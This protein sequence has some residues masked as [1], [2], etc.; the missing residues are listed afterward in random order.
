MQ[1]P[2]DAPEIRNAKKRCNR[3]R[4]KQR[5]WHPVGVRSGQEARKSIKKKKK[6][7]RQKGEKELQQNEASTGPSGGECE[8]PRG[9]GPKIVPDK[10]GEKRTSFGPAEGV[11]RVRGRVWAGGGSGPDRRWVTCSRH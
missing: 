1:A 3:S 6:T 11:I 8:H 4:Q 10:R 5:Y 2:V 7:K 9:P